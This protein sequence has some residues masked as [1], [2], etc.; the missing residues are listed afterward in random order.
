MSRNAFK[1]KTRRKPAKFI[2]REHCVK[3]VKKRRSSQFRNV[4]HYPTRPNLNALFGYRNFMICDLTRSVR[5]SLMAIL[6]SRS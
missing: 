2:V 3:P 6:N 1:R 5:S 4:I